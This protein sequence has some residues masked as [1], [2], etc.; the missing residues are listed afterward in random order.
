M[1][2]RVSLASFALCI[3]A[4]LAAPTRS[5][6]ADRLVERGARLAHDPSPLK[7]I[8]GEFGS[9]I[10]NGTVQ[11]QYSSNWAGAVQTAPPAGTTFGAI[12]GSF[13]VPT[14]SAPEGS[15]GGSYAA[16][17]WAG[18]DGDTYGN[19]ILQAGCDF[20]YDNGASYDCWYE[21]YPNPLTYFDGFTPS[22]GDTINVALKSLSPSQGTAVLTNQNTG[23]SVSKT[24][25]APSSTATLRGQNAEWIVEDFSSGGSLV[26]FVDFGTVT[27]TGCAA[28]AGG[29]TVGTAGAETLEITGSGGNVLTGVTFPDASSVQIV[30]Q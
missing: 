16:S 4:V 19:A 5:S 13:N 25:D 22:A 3:A 15:S 11:V 17:A 28:T 20:T 30:Y 18:I 7:T 29:Q 24:F 21:W 1:S 10:E 26:P 6:L 23:Q 14:P 9:T 8:K 2:F 27:F 12:S